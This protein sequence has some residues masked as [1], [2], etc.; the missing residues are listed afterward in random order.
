VSKQPAVAAS[1]LCWALLQV[2]PAALLAFE[3]STCYPRPAMSTAGAASPRPMWLSGIN[4]MRLCSIMRCAGGRQI[5]STCRQAG[6]HAAGRATCL[7][8][9]LEAMLPLPPH[10]LHGPL[11]PLQTLAYWW[12]WRDTRGCTTRRRSV[13]EIQDLFQNKRLEF[14]GD[15]H[16]RY[17]HNYIAR[18]LGGELGQPEE[19][20]APSAL[21]CECRAMCGHCRHCSPGARQQK[22]MPPASYAHTHIHT[23]VSVHACVCCRGRAAQGTPG[24]PTSQ[25]GLWPAADHPRGRMDADQGDLLR[26]AARP[27]AV[28]MVGCAALGCAQRRMVSQRWMVSRGGWSASGAQLAMHSLAGR[29]QGVL[30]RPPPLLPTKVT[31]SG[32][33]ACLQAGALARGPSAGCPCV[34]YTGTT[35]PVSACCLA[36]CCAVLCCCCS[37]F[38][39]GRASSSNGCVSKLSRA[40]QR[41]SRGFPR[42]PAD[43]HLSWRGCGGFA[44]QSTRRRCSPSL[45]H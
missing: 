9:A 21:C 35:E 2:H 7:R 18:T 33:A 3:P 23:H 31:W 25:A 28:N 40:C 19:R 4:P 34:A 26:L 5:D 12:V 36:L 44:G 22:L 45:T 29:V 15:S 30:C 8:L 24:R 10:R 42:K 13:S 41:V 14:V 37:V 27:H 38:G 43:N 16:I 39:A 17:L 11:L 20:C 6:M 1:W 32:P